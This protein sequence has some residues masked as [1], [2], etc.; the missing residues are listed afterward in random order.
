MLRDFEDL[1]ENWV[2]RS[3][4]RAY[5]AATETIPALLEKRQ[6]NR[7]LFEDAPVCFL[8]SMAEFMS[9]THPPLYN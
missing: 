3:E 2:S 7:S 1:S 4:F 5:A 8:V 6:T 9:S